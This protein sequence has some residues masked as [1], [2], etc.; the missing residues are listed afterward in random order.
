MA[1]RNNGSRRRKA[2]ADFKENQYN[3]SFSISESQK[4]KIFFKTVFRYVFI[5]LITLVFI[6][7]GFVISDALLDISEA[8]YHDTK[9]YTPTNTTAESTTL[10]PTNP[11]SE[12]DESNSDPS[13]TDNSSEASSQANDETQPDYQNNPEQE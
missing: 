2:F 7:V 10:L 9:V 1:E 5:I 8:E 11:S 4:R 12:A 13:N 3:D 6:A